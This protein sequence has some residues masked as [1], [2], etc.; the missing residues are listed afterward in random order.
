MVSPAPP[1]HPSEQTRYC[2]TS[3]EWR[4]QISRLLL[5]QCTFTKTRSTTK[6]RSYPDSI[7]TIP[8]RCVCGHCRIVLLSWSLSRRQAVTSFL[9]ARGPSCRSCS[10]PVRSPY[11]WIQRLFTCANYALRPQTQN[12]N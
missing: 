5:E 4:G 6:P 7:S 10:V 1:G 12:S 11:L 3:V 2:S 8:V 9:V